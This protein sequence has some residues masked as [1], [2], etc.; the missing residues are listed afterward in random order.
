MRSEHS[1]DNIQKL[2][3]A[4]YR[5]AHRQPG[6]NTLSNSRCRLQLPRQ[7]A[8]TARSALLGT[9]QGKSNGCLNTRPEDGLV[10]HADGVTSL[11]AARFIM[12][13]CAGSQHL[14]SASHPTIPTWQPRLDPQW[15]KT[16]RR[17]LSLFG[18]WRN[19]SANRT[20]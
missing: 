12:V 10:S 15:R 17:F 14:W 3:A 6:T 13:V 7:A 11:L 19:M 8:G 20:Q 4:R 5:R 16:C 9:T 18:R 2:R 1:P